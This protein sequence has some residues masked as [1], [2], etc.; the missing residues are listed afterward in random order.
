M[1][2]GNRLSVE[3]YLFGTAEDAEAAREEAGKMLWLVVGG[4]GRGCQGDKVMGVS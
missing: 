3:G 2:E 1:E 4:A